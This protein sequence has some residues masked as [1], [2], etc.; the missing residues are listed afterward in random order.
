MLNIFSCLI[1]VCFN[2]FILRNEFSVEVEASVK[3]FPT[4]KVSNIKDSDTQQ[5][6]FKRAQNRVSLARYKM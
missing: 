2:R 5:K 4:L 1:V 6:K 3:M